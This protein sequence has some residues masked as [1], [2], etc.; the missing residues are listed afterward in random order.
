MR[1]MLQVRSSGRIGL[2]C[3]QHRNSLAPAHTE[4][5]RHGMGTANASESESSVS[6]LRT[7][8]EIYTSTDQPPLPRGTAQPEPSIEPLVP[9]DG[10]GK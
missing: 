6:H 5:V 9:Q 2:V 8:V 3:D 10:H 1:T 7:S 4:I